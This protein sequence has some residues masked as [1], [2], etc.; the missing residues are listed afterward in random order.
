MSR[1]MNRRQ[2]VAAATSAG[3]GLALSRATQ[4]AE[5]PAALGGKPVRTKS[6]QSWPLVDPAAEKSVLDVVR[7]GHWNRNGVVDD[8]EE[9]F[10]ELNGAKYCVATASGTTALYTSLGALGVGPGDEVIVPPYTFVATVNVALLHYAMPVFVD[11]DRETFMMDPGK[12]EAA[13]TDRTAAII[14]VHIGGS[15]ADM[16]SILAIARKRNVPVIED[17]CQAHGASWRGKSVGTLGDGAAFSFQ[18]SKHINCGAGGAI[19]LATADR[20]MMLEH[21]VYSVISPEGCASILWRTGDKAAEAAEA[22]KVTATDLEKLGVV[23]RVVPEPV[24]GAHRD[25]A[26]ANRVT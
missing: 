3:V 22:M 6:Y 13:I 10:A 17:A 2:F 9:A 26:A 23:D 1:K 5:K 18:A 7:S 16:D 25:P 19:A 11:S 14:P 24:G 12:L 21:A 20:V 8:F 15:A 4:A